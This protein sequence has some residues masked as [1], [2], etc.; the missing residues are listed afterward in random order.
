MKDWTESRQEKTRIRVEMTN[1]IKERSE[2]R[3]KRIVG[4]RAGSFADAEQWDLE[5]WQ[6]QTPQMRLSALVE[7]REGLA[8]IPGR[9]RMFDNE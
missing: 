2:M 6:S 8:L 3:R 4:H 7:L 1:G 9:N 5:F